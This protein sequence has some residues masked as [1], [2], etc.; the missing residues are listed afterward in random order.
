[1]VRTRISLE[2]ILPGTPFQEISNILS[3][4][5]VDEWWVG[6]LSHTKTDPRYYKGLKDYMA[7][8]IKALGTADR[9]HFKQE[10]GAFPG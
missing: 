9:I 4:D 5:F 2:P 1:G 6:I 7:G 8:K 3:L 10:I